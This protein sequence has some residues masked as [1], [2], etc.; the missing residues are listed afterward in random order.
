MDFIEALPKVNRKTDSH[1]GGPTVQGGAL[2]SARPPLHSD[3]S[4]A[5]VLSRNCVPARHP[6]HHCQRWGPM[7]TSEFWRELFRLAGV[8]LQMTSAFHPQADEQSEAT[9][10]I[11]AMYLRCLTGDRPRQWLE[12]LSWAEFCYNLSCQQSL[13]TSPFHLVYGRLPSLIHSYASGDARLP[14]V[15]KEM[16]DRDEFLC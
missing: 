6:V 5:R 3:D 11:I 7:F 9:N 10:K 15:D 16:R 12:W 4:G 2:H 13:K 14:A 8:K 1:G